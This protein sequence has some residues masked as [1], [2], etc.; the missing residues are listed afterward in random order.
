M[1]YD[2][3]ISYETKTGTSY[4]KNLKEAF[5]KNK[6]D[7]QNIFL[8]DRSLLATHEW[9]KKIDDALV[10]AP[11][12]II[13]FT[14]L[15]NSSD[16]VKKECKKAIKLEKRIMT[17]RWHEIPISETKKLAERLVDFQQIEF[18]DKYDLANKVLSKIRRLREEQNNDI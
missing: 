3:F 10:E 13:I 2:V 4:A 15:T 5:E 14:S 6:E 12:F 17:C 16:E 18:E 9:E 8:A 1:A 11:L 7:T